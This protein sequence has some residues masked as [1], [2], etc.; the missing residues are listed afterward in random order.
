MEWVQSTIEK[1]SRQAVFPGRALALTVALSPFT[2]QVTKSRLVAHAGSIP[3]TRENDKSWNGVLIFL[4]SEMGEI[5]LSYAVRLSVSRTV[6]M[7]KATIDQEEGAAGSPQLAGRAAGVAK[8]GL[9]AL[10]VLFSSF[11]IRLFLRAQLR[12]KVLGE[13]A[14]SRLFI[15]PSFWSFVFGGFLSV[16]PFGRLNFVLSQPV[17]MFV[18]NVFDQAEV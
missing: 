11:V 12:K 3:I 16:F 5:L 14:S 4:A 8:A 7:G 6:E 10:G 15:S 1:L 2:W 18:S 9:I 17:K 13:Q